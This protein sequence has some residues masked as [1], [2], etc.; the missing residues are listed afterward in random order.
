MKNKNALLSLFVAAAV[1]FT[2]FPL[3]A[4]TSTTSPRPIETQQALQPAGVSLPVVNAPVV[5]PRAESTAPV[6]NKTS[7]YG[8]SWRE[9]WGYGGFIMWIL[10]AISILM[11]ALVI[12]FL[13][14]FRESAVAPR[15]LVSEIRDNFRE[16]DMQAVRHAC[17]LHP[18]PVSALAL[19]AVDFH[20]T[21]EG[22]DD[23]Q[24]LRD[25]VESEGTRQAE[26]M[27]SQTQLLLDLSAIAPMLGLLGTTLGM[28]KAFGAV[29]HDIVAAAK[30][31]LLAQ[32]VSEAIVTTIF[33]LIVAIPCM[34][35]YAF[36]RRRTSRLTGLLEGAATDILASFPNRRGSLA[37]R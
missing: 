29:A 13:C 27:Q 19:A 9:A 1:L 34:A 30:P 2:S 36:F 21:T 18:C 8:M 24:L 3:V 12:Y 7:A 23:R 6:E 32:G 25:V 26:S 35:F 37:D 5:A 33:G 20:D 16:G 17:E 10:L 11:I 14:V 28:L 4:Q 31:V 22:E 15:R